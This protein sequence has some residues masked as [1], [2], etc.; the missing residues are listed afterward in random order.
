MLNF[1]KQ[2]LGKVTG[3]NLIFKWQ[4]QS[5][6]LLGVHL[7]APLSYSR[8]T[9]RKIQI[10]A[11][12]NWIL[13][14]NLPTILIGDLNTTP[15]SNEFKV[16]TTHL[17]NSMLGFGIQA[18]WPFHNTFVSFL[19]IPLDHALHSNDIKTLKR[20][21][22]RSGDSNHKPLLLEFSVSYPHPEQ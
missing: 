14:Q 15:W 4:N 22:E 20:T 10:E 18:T 17:K 3:G 1:I 11:I 9:K 13:Q 21:V 12:Q 16:L 7:S 19:R 5:I 6:S 8:I 2:P